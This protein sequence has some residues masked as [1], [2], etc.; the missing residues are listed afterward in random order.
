[1][2]N[3]CVPCHRIHNDTY[4]KYSLYRTVYGEKYGYFCSLWFKPSKPEFVPPRVKEQ[5]NEFAKSL[6]QPTRGGEW[7]KEYIDAFG[8]KNLNITEKEARNA[9]P[10]WKDILPSQWEKSK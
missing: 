2:R 6:L 8:T 5:R 10:V 4:W 3:L 1:V 9:K 7:S